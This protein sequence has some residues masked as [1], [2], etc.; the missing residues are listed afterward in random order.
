[1][2]CIETFSS[3]VTLLIVAHR[4]T[5]LKNCDQIFEIKNGGISKGVNYQNIIS[6]SA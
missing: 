5:T 3:Q 1:M 6:R 2:R 4:M